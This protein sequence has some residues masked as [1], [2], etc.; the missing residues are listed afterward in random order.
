[1]NNQVSASTEL[2]YEQHYV[3]GLFARLDREVQAAQE[4]L[5][6]VQLRIDP[7]DADPEALIDRETEYHS[8]NARI[9]ALNIAQ[10]GLVFGRIDVQVENPEFIDNPVSGRD[11]LDRRYV[12]RMGLDDR[13]DDY[14]TLLLDWRAPQ[15]RPFYLATTAQ[16]EGVELRRHIRTHGRNVTAVTDEV[17][18]GQQFS[19]SE[20]LA[21]GVGSESALFAA[22]QAAR[23][24]HMSSIVETIQRE[25]DEIIRDNY[26]GVMVVEGGPGTGKTAVAL[27]RV[28][29]L[30]Y[31]WREQ[32]ARTGVLIIGPNQTFLEYISR[33]LPELGETGVVL[34]TVGDLYPGITPVYEDSLLVREVK[35]S[36]EMVTILQ[37]LVKDYQRVPEAPHT[38]ILDGITLTLTAK[39][40]KTA[41]TRARRSRKPHNHAQGIFT[42]ALIDQIAQ[43]MVNIIGTDPLH[44]A[45]LLSNADQAQIHDDITEEPIIAELVERYWP[46]LQPL[47]ILA[48]FFADCDQIASIAYDYDE[49][50]Q[51]ALYREHTGAWSAADAALLDELAQLIGI[52]E[53]EDID[54][55]WNAEFTAAENTLEGLSS[56]ANSDL[57]DETDAEILSAFDVIDAQQLASRQERSDHRSTAQRAAQDLQWAYGHVIIDEAQELSAMEW[58]MVMRKIPS[59]W[60][61]LVGDTSQTGSPAGVDSWEETLQ[62]FVEKRFR[63]HLLTINYRTPKAIMD[64]AHELLEQFSPE[65]L[66]STSLRVTDAAVTFLDDSHD[67]II[68][69]R[70]LRDAEPERLTA[71]IS[72]DSLGQGEIIGISQAK[73]LEFD[74]VIVWQPLQFFED[75]PQGYQDLFVA[76]TRATQTLTIIGECGELF[77]Q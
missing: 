26:R 64:V 33:V 2:E 65:T 54:R 19:H 21:Q 5:A 17:L 53:Q 8:L 20:V 13:D 31:T 47:N 28:A 41:R 32:L 37:R 36:I 7:H 34:A 39:M 76:L 27:H 23:S 77:T 6:E 55:D 12:G 44:G 57:D 43:Q 58:R 52:D 69:A 1:M 60:M 14:R 4:K 22:L 49:T 11:N 24:G 63:K 42:E 59:R 56:S 70:T 35:G 50:T 40:V 51:Q 16:P 68:Y 3:T 74:H 18:S 10:L 46:R 73:G 25:Q 15:A 29:Y 48:D 61:T 72:A 9:D 45:N 62:P 71:I 75:S 67:P 30:L 38:F 66:H